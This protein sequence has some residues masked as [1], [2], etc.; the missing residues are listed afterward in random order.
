L[1]TFASLSHHTLKSFIKFCSSQGQNLNAAIMCFQAK[2]TKTVAQ[3]FHK[4][5][6]LPKHLS[7]NSG[8]FGMSSLLCF[9]GWRATKLMKN[10]SH[11]KL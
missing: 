10:K 7:K 2:M 8:L 6:G 5:G 9:L 1:E 4:E 3:A 11:L